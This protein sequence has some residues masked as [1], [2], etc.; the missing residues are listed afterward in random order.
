MTSSGT[1]SQPHRVDPSHLGRLR[2]RDAVEMTSASP[3]AT[4]NM[5]MVAMKAA[6]AHN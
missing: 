4:D 5:A 1:G 6:G 2:Y 3:R